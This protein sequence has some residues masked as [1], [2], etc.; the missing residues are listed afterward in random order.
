[1][2]PVLCLLLNAAFSKAARVIAGNSLTR[3][4]VCGYWHGASTSF[5]NWISHN[6]VRRNLSAVFPDLKQNEP[7]KAFRD[8][9]ELRAEST[10][11]EQ[12]DLAYSIHWAIVDTEL[13][14]TQLPA[15]AVEPY[16]VIERRRALEWMLTD[17]CWEDI[18]LDT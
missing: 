17:E 6:T 2:L 11:I 14:K 15:Q 1:M 5:L 12:C 13:K 3:L 8:R 7:G 4:K 9:A 10:I 18:S 16:V